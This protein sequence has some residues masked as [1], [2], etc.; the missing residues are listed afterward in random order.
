[1]QCRFIIL[2]LLLAGPVVLVAA[3][4]ERMDRSEQAARYPRCMGRVVAIRRRRMPKPEGGAQTAYDT[5]VAYVVDGRAYRT[6]ITVFPGEI[7]HLPGS[8][9]PLLYEMQHPEHVEQERKRVAVREF[10]KRSSHRNREMLCAQSLEEKSNLLR[11]GYRMFG[12][13]GRCLRY[14]LRRNRPRF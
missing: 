6:T 5:T 11:C 4:A 12:L 14:C 2:L 13:L 8:Q 1:M 9:I 3:L 7:V 10:I